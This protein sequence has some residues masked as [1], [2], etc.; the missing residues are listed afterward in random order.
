[1]PPSAG[2]KPAAWLAPGAG[3]GLHA[4]EPLT[5]PVDWYRGALA[6]ARA[7]RPA[8]AVLRHCIQTNGTL[9]DDRWC[10]LFRE[11]GMQIGIQP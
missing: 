10:G 9:I 1:M 6:A 4:G 2:W 7:A 11:H 3:G 8:G 5:L